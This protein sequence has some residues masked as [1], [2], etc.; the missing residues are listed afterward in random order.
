M[1]DSCNSRYNILIRLFCACPYEFAFCLAG[2]C[3]V[4]LA[5]DFNS[6]PDSPL[7][8]DFLL[9]QGLDLTQ[10]QYKV[11][12]ISG[13]NNT[14]FRNGRSSRLLSPTEVPPRGSGIT[15][16]CIFAEDKSAASANIGSGTLTQPFNF[17]S[18]NTYWLD[19][20]ALKAPRSS[21]SPHEA[22]SDSNH[23]IVPCGEVPSS[24]LLLL[25]HPALTRPLKPGNRGFG[26]LVTSFTSANTCAVDYILFANSSS[27][28]TAT[29]ASAS[30]VSESRPA[31]DYGTLR[32]VSHCLLVDP[33]TLHSA[34][35][36]PNAAAGSDH[37]PLTA[38]FELI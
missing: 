2:H 17:Q 22:G 12:D 7:V 27:Q 33:A 5:G 20:S 13:Q 35:G 25:D 3:P 9:G 28:S 16:E 34:G 15:D 38:T 36:L 10:R 26:R 6:E 24:H 21:C 19:V 37:I 18:T 1:P 31:S 32:L 23:L 30:M 4:V 8:T 11:S 14:S 29:T